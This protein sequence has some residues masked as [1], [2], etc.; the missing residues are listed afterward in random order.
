MKLK[1]LL[2]EDDQAI[3]ELIRYNLEAEGYDVTSTEDGE[4]ALLLAEEVGPDVVLLDWMLPSLSGIEICRRLRKEA[5]TANV[6]I[7]MITARSEES[8]L[9]RGLE[10]GADDYII[11]PFSPKELMARV[12]SVLR[13]VR[14]AFAAENL[15]FEDIEMDKITHR[16]TRNGAALKLGPIEYRLLRHFMENPKHVFSRDQ[17]LDRVWGQDVFIDERTVDVHIRRLRKALEVDDLPDYIRTVRSM[18]YAL[19]IS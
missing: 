12:H 16:V 5:A 6:P 13:R 4:E 10:T 15:K 9:I 2:V 14:P 11:K 8:D 17:L 3:S 19:D 18:G 7:L 1:A